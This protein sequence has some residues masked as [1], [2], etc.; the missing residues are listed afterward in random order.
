MEKEKTKVGKFLG[1]LGTAGGK[2]LGDI[3]AGVNP[4]SAI[5]SSLNVG[6]I[7]QEDAEAA[8][9]LH[10]LDLEDVKNARENKTK[11]TTS[12][13]SPFISKII[14]EVIAIVIIGAWIYS[15][16]RQ[17]II[18]SSE[19]ASAVMLILGYLFGRTSPNK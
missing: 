1:G 4:V 6:D 7:K 13:N 8:L 18:P 10:E 12:E 14:H 9:N 5:L 16:Y 15:W 2:I 3:V 17:T 19:I 11:I